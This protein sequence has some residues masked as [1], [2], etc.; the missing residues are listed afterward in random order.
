VDFNTLQRSKPALHFAYREQAA[1]LLHRVAVGHAG[2]VVR[3]CALYAPACRHFLILGRQQAWIGNEG[4]EQVM[5][6]SRAPW[7]VMRKHLEML[8]QVLAQK[9]LECAI[10]CSASR[11]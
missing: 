6:H 5:D 10:L 11:R 7:H 4:T 3:R 2:N 9:A 8:V 1:V